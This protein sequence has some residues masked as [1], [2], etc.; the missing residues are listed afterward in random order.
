[1]AA[2]NA[3]HQPSRTASGAAGMATQCSRGE[4]RSVRLLACAGSGAISAISFIGTGLGTSGAA[5]AL[6]CSAQSLAIELFMNVS[7]P[8]GDSTASS[9]PLIG[10]VCIVYTPPSGTLDATRSSV[11][12]SSAGSSRVPGSGADRST[13]SVVVPSSVLA[14]SLSSGGGRRMWARH[15]SPRRPG[16]GGG[17]GARASAARRPSGCHSCGQLWP[18]CS[19]RMPAAISG[20]STAR[21]R[22]ASGTGGAAPYR[23]DAD[24]GS[25]ALSLVSGALLERSGQ[26]CH[27]WRSRGRLGERPGS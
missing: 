5:A 18:V 13:S 6:G 20:L 21:V 8:D 24:P 12:R 11:R 16:G 4:S 2:S 22:V 26:T 3:L 15:G 7:M 19:Q 17:G 1:M 10:L 25:L 14:K 23:P 9:M 27:R